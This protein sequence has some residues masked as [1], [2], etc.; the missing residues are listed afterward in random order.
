[1]LKPFFSL[2][3]AAI[4]T[5]L[6]I[7]TLLASCSSEAPIAKDL[8]Q[9]SVIPKPVVLTA[10]GSSFELTA[11]TQIYVQSNDDK[12]SW[13]A[14]Y[15]TDLLN[16]ATGFELSV[17]TTDQ[18]PGNNS[19]YLNLSGDASLGA[20]GYQLDITNKSITISGHQAAGVFYGVQTLRHLLP[21]AIEKSSQ[22]EGPWLVASGTMKDQPSYGYRG[23]MLDVA[24]HFFK[25]EDVKR[26]IDYIAMYKLNHFHLHLTDDQG[27]RIEIKSWPNLTTHGGSTEVGGGEGGY[28]TQEQYADIVQYAQNRFITIVPEIDLPGH[29]NAALASYAELNCD[30]K[31]RELYTGTEVGFSTLCTDKEITYQFVDDVVK[32]LAALT[33]GEYI[34]IGG[35]ESH[36]TPLEDYIPFINRTQKIVEK[37]GKKVM[38]WDEIA[39]AELLPNTVVQWWAKPENAEKAIA[40]G[41]KVLVSPATKVYLD[42]QY[43][44]TTHLGLHWAAYI[45]VDAAYNWDVDT[46]AAGLTKDNVIGFES[47]LWSETIT[48]LDELEY[49]VFPRLLGH[50]EIG[51]SPKEIRSWDDYKVRLGKQK[52][53]FEALGIDFYASDLIPWSDEPAK[54]ETEVPN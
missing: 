39:H 4:M 35:D 7:T 41:A 24:R 34:H 29:T 54:V 8:A 26:Y 36:V 42:M 51:W 28:Y 49:M 43:D 11:E 45:E 10:T 19:I 53:R 30:G 20:E 23:A 46:L 5:G 13:I 1:M 44:T 48:N 2:V 50:A 37:Y 47:P 25:V 22:Q 40:Q 15:L 38:G 9:E 17:Q 21:P 16:P 12:L 31:A 3:N 33:P 32:E 14:N 27:W 6:L 52:A 18:A